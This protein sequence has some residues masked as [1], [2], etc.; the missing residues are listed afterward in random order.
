MERLMRDAE[1]LAGYEIGSLKTDNFADVIEA[2]HLVQEEMGIT[3]TTAQ[4]ASTTIEG[5]VSSMQAAWS[6]WLTEL[7]KDNGDVAARTQELID[8]VFGDGEGNPGVVGNVVPRVLQIGEQIIANLPDIM[9]RIGAAIHDNIVPKLDEITGGKASEFIAAF[10]N[11]GKKV[12]EVFEK[13][14]PHIDKLIEQLGPILTD[15]ILPALTTAFNIIGDVISVVG[16]AIAWIVDRISDFLGVVNSIVDAVSAAAEAAANFLGISGSGGGWEDSGG[17]FSSSGG[18]DFGSSSH[19]VGGGGGHYTMADGGRVTGPTY[20]LIGE[21][22]YDEY[23][24]PNTRSGMQPLADNLADELGRRDDELIASIYSVRD[25]IKD[26][27]V[28]LDGNKLVGGI[29]SR[30][31][32]ALVMM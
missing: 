7:G 15:V 18:G 14:K 31:S 4:E 10:E 12:G 1:R 13:L 17:G 26:M 2:I 25:E 21:A 9:S 5:S 29:Q 16:D 22:G 32:R 8:S 19:I 24:V 23:V 27:G 6:N 3:G 20:A 28:Y 30:M 11:I